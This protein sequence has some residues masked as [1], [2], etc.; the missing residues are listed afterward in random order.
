MQ[1]KLD[2]VAVIGHCETPG[3]TVLILDTTYFGRGFGVMVFRC[4]WRHKNLSWGF[5]EYET[6]EGYVTGVRELE[7]AGWIISGIV[8]DGRRG[9]FEAFGGIPMQMCQFHQVQ[10][11][12]RYITRWPKLPAGKELRKIILLL[13]ETD[14]AS[15]SFW[16]K[17]WHEKW[18]DFLGEKTYDIKIKRYRYVHRRLRSAYR[19]LKTHL[20][21]L[22]TFER[23]AELNMPNTTNS[24][25]GAFSHVKEKIRVHR[26]LKTHRRNKLIN[27]LLSGNSQP[28]TFVH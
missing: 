7:K 14:E 11:V 20:P 18:K 16:L 5:V 24:L 28:Q 4:A 1:R 15:F 21:Y 10:I 9:L 25:D 8:C 27:Q 26:G 19:S 17:E 6:V 2:R 3:E 23:H 13:K 12:T 22:F